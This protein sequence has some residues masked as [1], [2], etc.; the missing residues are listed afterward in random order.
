M[1]EAV[2]VNVD[3]INLAYCLVV[4]NC[5]E[6]YT[7]AIAYEDDLEDEPVRKATDY[8][9][10]CGESIFRGFLLLHEGVTILQEG[11]ATEDENE[12]QQ[13]VGKESD[14][15]LYDKKMSPLDD[16]KKAKTDPEE[17]R[18]ILRNNYNPEYLKMNKLSPRK[19]I[20]EKKLG[21]NHGKESYSYSLWSKQTDRVLLARN[22]HVC[23]PLCDSESDLTATEDEGDSTR[24]RQK[25]LNIQFQEGTS[26]FNESVAFDGS[27]V[28]ISKSCLQRAKSKFREVQKLLASFS[29]DQSLIDFHRLSLS[30]TIL[31]CVD[32]LTLGI[33]DCKRLITEMN[34]MSN[35][36]SMITRAL[37]GPRT[38]KDRLTKRLHDK[39]WR[40]ILSLVHF[41]NYIVWKW[42]MLAGKETGSGQTIGI[43]SI[44]TG[45]GLIHPTDEW[46]VRDKCQTCVEFV[47]KIP[48]SCTLAVNSKDQLIIIDSRN[49]VTVYTLEGKPLLSFKA[50]T[51]RHPHSRWIIGVDSK[52]NIYVGSA[53][54]ILSE[55]KRPLSIFT[56]T[57][58]LLA[59]P[60]IV[61]YGGK[62]HLYAVTKSG[63]ILML[64]AGTP[65]GN[66]VSVH[67]RDSKLINSFQVREIALPRYFNSGND[68][69]I[70]G[71]STTN[72]SRDFAFQVCD[73]LGQQ[74]YFYKPDVEFQHCEVNPWTGSIVLV[75]TDTLRDFRYCL[76]NTVV[77]T[78]E[79]HILATDGQTIKSGINLRWPFRKV[80][81]VTVLRCGLVVVVTM[82]EPYYAIHVI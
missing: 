38:L 66:M 32:N 25:K 45:L 40:K 5:R 63:L 41:T 55:T 39:K 2:S 69:I 18:G 7:R 17:L 75:R 56:R 26:S 62:C 58:K 3:A 53:L 74:L 64:S 33:Q 43:P 6:D 16:E 4:F 1:V 22:E 36:Q 48:S 59:E 11:R 61:H 14:L 60:E 51:S 24:T 9:G 23:A 13:N 30:C 35:V 76:C 42:L 68:N 54:G 73:L 31:Q 57:G 71:G 72:E 21:G 29:N 8:W 65:T 44:E 79:V 27:M 77:L 52:D 10:D 81:G 15:E 34:S 46:S 78:G 19:R 28:D 12:N 67:Q 82:D 47:G 80:A 20:N 70:L 49:Y 50:S 37:K